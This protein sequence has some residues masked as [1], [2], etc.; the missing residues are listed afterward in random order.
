MRYPYPMC[1]GLIKGLKLNYCNKVNNDL[2]E[3]VVK[4]MQ[5]N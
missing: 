3:Q 4:T 2:P 5:R 1:E